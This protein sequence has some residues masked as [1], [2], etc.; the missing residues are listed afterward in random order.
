MYLE[1]INFLK[2]KGV[3]QPEIGL[4]LGSG[5]GELANEI[6]N[7]IEIPYEDIPNFPVS[8]VEGHEG[9]MVYG[10]LSGKRV[11]ALKGRFHYYEGYDL[12]DVTYPIRVFHE[13]GV[14]TLILTNAAGGV[15]ESFKPGDLMIINDHINLTGNNPLIGINIEDHGPR[16]VDLCETYSR[17]GRQLIKEISDDLAY[18]IKEGVYTWFTGPSYETP[19]EIRM[20]RTIGGDAVGMSTV[21]EAIVAK[22]CN[23]EVIGI[24]CITN[25]A[26]GMQANLNHQEVVE[27]SNIAK[28]KF[29]QLIKVLLERL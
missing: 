4:V 3:N 25:L 10:E 27:V 29:K 6:Q 17:S 9:K 24:S 21:P 14:K 15:N 8:T 13:L 18:D 7:P 2:S 23:M 12:A 26:A 28:P 19:A 22:H 11:V 1:I 5:L 20:V 16:F